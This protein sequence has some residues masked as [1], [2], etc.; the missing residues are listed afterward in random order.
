MATETQKLYF[1]IVRFR[2]HSDV[3]GVVIRNEFHVMARNTKEAKEK[4]FAKLDYNYDMS[5]YHKAGIN[6][7]IGTCR[8]GIRQSA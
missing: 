2:V 5:A 3:G 6:Y 8:D 4:I 7:E 1:A